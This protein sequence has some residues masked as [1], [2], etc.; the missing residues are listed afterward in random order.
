MSFLRDTSPPTISFIL[1]PEIQRLALTL[2]AFGKVESISFSQHKCSSISRDAIIF[3]IRSS[4]WIFSRHVRINEP[5][6]IPGPWPPLD[7]G[8]MVHEAG[9]TTAHPEGSH[10]FTNFPE[11][12]LSCFVDGH[13]AR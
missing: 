11:N 4:T 10:L 9:D 13:P 2:M 1:F 3:D 6:F 7:F 12:L 8:V 5:E